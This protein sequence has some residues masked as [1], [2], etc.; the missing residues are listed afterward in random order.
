MDTITPGK[1]HGYFSGSKIG[2]NGKKIILENFSH[3][4]P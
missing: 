2:S 4:L 1:L 3:A